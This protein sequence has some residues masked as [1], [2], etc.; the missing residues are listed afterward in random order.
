MRTIKGKQYRKIRLLG[1]GNFAKVYV[2]SDM[3]SGKSTILIDIRVLDYTEYIVRSNVILLTIKR[4]IGGAKSPE[5]G[6]QLGA[7]NTFGDA[8]TSPRNL[9]RK[10][11]LRCLYCL[12]VRVWQWCLGD[13]LLQIWYF[14]GSLCSFET[15]A[16]YKITYNETIHILFRSSIAEYDASS[17]S[18]R[19]SSW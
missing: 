6:A 14:I 9:H 15:N 4:P 10:C 5:K 16:C 7:N 19:N 8:E 13:E 12:Y 18:K 1:E 17:T 11:N 2:C 3:D